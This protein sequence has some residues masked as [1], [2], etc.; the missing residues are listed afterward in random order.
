M[1]SK[2]KNQ[3]VQRKSTR[4]STCAE[5]TKKGM[6]CFPQLF[7]HTRFHQECGD[8]CA[9]HRKQ[10]LFKIFHM[11]LDGVTVEDK[12]H[13]QA[14][15]EIA[16]LRILSPTNNLKLFRMTEEKRYEHI[17]HEQIQTWVDMIT[18]GGETSW[19][20]EMVG[21]VLPSN[22]AEVIAYWEKLEVKL[23]PSIF[24]LSQGLAFEGMKPKNV[25][26]CDINF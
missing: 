16:T 13:I 23:D 25:L 2:R 20:F 19:S 15:F 18:D 1:T 7:K 9:E 26:L 6:G 21:D 11:L 24:K 12:N 8:Y 3:V 17:S 22:I 5:K 4:L 14:D 10:I